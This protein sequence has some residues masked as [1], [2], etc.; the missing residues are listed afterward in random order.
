MPEESKCLNVAYALIEGG[1]T[2]IL[3]KMYYVKCIMKPVK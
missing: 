3:V 1:K 2:Q